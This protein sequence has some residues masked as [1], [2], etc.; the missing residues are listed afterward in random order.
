[1]TISDSERYS[2]DGFHLSSSLFSK[3]N[4]MLSISTHCQD[5]AALDIS[6]SH[7]FIVNVKIPIEKLHSMCHLYV[8][9]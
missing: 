3:F 6:E 4:W 7:L 8:F 2:S 1:M 5:K 9:F